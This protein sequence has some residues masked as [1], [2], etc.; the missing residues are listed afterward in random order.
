MGDTRPEFLRSASQTSLPPP[1]C[2]ILEFSHL[3]K[4]CL[5][6]VHVYL[7][8]IST[9]VR[10][11]C[12]FFLFLLTN[13]IMY[14]TTI[15]SKSGRSLCHGWSTR[16][17]IFATTSS[18]S[19]QSSAF[20]SLSRVGPLPSSAS[21]PGRRGQ[22]PRAYISTSHPLAA[23]ALFRSDLINCKRVV[24]KLGSAVITREDECGLALGR[25]ASIVEQVRAGKSCLVKGRSLYSGKLYY[26]D[27]AS[28]RK[29]WCKMKICKV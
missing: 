16:S 29:L 19:N 5:T 13:S 7:H 21:P 20:S 8:S 22:E 12:D 23:Q 2:Q 24:I 18:P 6:F 4:K 15:L 9:L 26:Y 11:F 10:I 3:D 14:Y 25:L 27:H 28:G 17:L 1:N